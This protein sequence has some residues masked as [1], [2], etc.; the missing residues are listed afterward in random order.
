[1]E[2]RR[3]AFFEP[4]QSAVRCT[5]CPRRCRIADGETGFC[6][7]RRNKNGI[8][9]A[10]SYGRP[11]A[12]QVDPIEKKPL[13][14]FFPGSFALSFGTFGCNLSCD[15][16][17]NHSLSCGRY[18]VPAE[19]SQETAPEELVQLARRHHCS[20]IAFTYNEP[21]VFFEYMLDTA[22]AAKSAGLLTVLVSNACIEPEPAAELFPWIDAANFDLKSIRREFYQKHCAGSLDAV[23]R[24]IEA[25]Y[26][27]GRHLEL[28]NLV[29]PQENDSEE[30]IFDYLD[31]VETRLSRTVPLHFSAFFPC[32]RLQ[33]RPTT[34]RETILKIREYAERRGFRH[35]YCGN[36]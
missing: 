10:E 6:G 30:E 27:T 16:C 28:T 22:K 1:M 2:R 9:Y 17:Q 35:V 15:F 24:T 12:I 13:R 5:L 32:H 20:S 25:F 34:P 29:I 7:V 14:E 33:N 21:T 4:E 26:Q 19:E 8:L 31:Y 18:P 23:Q 36:I 11:A 3:S